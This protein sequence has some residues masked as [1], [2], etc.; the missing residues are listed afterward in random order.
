MSL[1]IGKRQEM[2]EG[3]PENIRYLPEQVKDELVKSGFSD[4]S[5][6]NDL[7]KHFLVVGKKDCQRRVTV[8]SGRI[9][10]EIGR[11]VI[12]CQLSTLPLLYSVCHL[13]HALK[14]API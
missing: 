9:V 3:P 1:S 7:T 10:R 13:R 8:C 6:Y 14:R 2:P 4:V 5:I 12:S 11:T